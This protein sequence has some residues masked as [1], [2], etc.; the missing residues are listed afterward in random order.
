MAVHEWKCALVSFWGIVV[1]GCITLLTMCMVGVES[2]DSVVFYA[3][4]IDRVAGL[5]KFAIVA[6]LIEFSMSLLLRYLGLCAANRKEEV[7]S[8]MIT[9]AG[10][11]MKLSQCD[12]SSTD[13]YA[14]MM[15]RMTEL[16]NLRIDE[17]KS[18]TNTNP[19]P[20]AVSVE[21]SE[22]NAANSKDEISPASETSSSR[23]AANTD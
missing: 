16:L 13:D 7:E 10:I 8:M 23:S 18:D 15:K 14:E 12:E 6:A 9:C 3:M 19:K 4:M 22:I 5:A 11:A 20:C 17:Q 1:V 2:M 21:S